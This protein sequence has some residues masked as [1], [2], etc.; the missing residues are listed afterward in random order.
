LKQERRSKKTRKFG[1]YD[2]SSPSEHVFIPVLFRCG[3]T[4]EDVQEEAKKALKEWDNARKS[5]EELE[6]FVKVT[7]E[8]RIMLLAFR[9]SPTT[10]L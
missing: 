4:L 7:N 9:D 10:L 5:I 3:A 6:G 2:I 1:L 8:L